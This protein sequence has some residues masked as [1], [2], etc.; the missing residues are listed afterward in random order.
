VLT[1]FSSLPGLDFEDFDSNLP[2]CLEV[3]G[4]LDSLKFKRTLV[5]N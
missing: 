5:R 2:L 4:K 1:K 3:V